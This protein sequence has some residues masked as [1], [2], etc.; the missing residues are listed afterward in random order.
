M[1]GATRD[2]TDIEII[3][4]RHPDARKILLTFPVLHRGWEMDN[5]AWLVEMADGSRQLFYTSH[6]GVYPMKRGNLK[7]KI[8]EYESV[9]KLSKEALEMLR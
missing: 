1:P 9:I 4:L 2:L 7:K 5:D 3:Q 6:G 8:A